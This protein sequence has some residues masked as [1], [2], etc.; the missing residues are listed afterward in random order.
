MSKSLFLNQTAEYMV[1][2]FMEARK[3]VG[4]LARVRVET[5]TFALS[6]GQ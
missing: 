1:M 4:F 6:V 3:T 5:Y 2:P